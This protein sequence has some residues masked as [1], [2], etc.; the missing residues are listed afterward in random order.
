[1]NEFETFEFRK[2]S[3]SKNQYDTITYLTISSRGTLFSVIQKS[4]TKY[5]S[6]ALYNWQNPNYSKIGVFNGFH[7][8]I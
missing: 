4:L 7:K 1:M 5:T 3:I 8:K 6:S 2:K